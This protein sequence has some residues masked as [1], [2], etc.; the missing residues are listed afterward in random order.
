M[1][2]EGMREVLLGLART[3]FA[4]ASEQLVLQSFIGQFWILPPAQLSQ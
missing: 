4:L 2:F 1:A 3:F